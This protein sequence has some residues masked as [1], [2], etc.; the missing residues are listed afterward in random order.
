M[1]VSGTICELRYVKTGK[2]RY[3]MEIDELEVIGSKET[4]PVLRTH[5]RFSGKIRFTSQKALV[6]DVYG[7]VD[8]MFPLVCPE[9]RDRLYLTFFL[10][11]KGDLIVRLSL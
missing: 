5:P 10:R 3:V 1:R 6:V 9:R 2:Y 4:N 7:K 11:V 8:G